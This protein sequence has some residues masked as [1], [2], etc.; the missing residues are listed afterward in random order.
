[1]STE[2]LKSPVVRVSNPEQNITLTGA[3]Y[4]DL[5]L[6]EYL[7]AENMRRCV[8]ALNLVS[9][10]GENE[11][12]TAVQAQ[13]QAMLNASAGVLSQYLRVAQLQGLHF[14]IVPQPGDLH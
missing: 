6:F 1:M 4:A 9:P 5:I 13:M 7:R 12:L 10:H 2:I 3:S 11:L 14:E 8:A